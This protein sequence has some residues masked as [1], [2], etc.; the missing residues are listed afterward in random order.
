GTVLAAR[1]RQMI[2]EATA[3]V[4]SVREI[5]QEPSGVLRVLL[6]VGV[7][8]HLMIPVFMA[9]RSTYPLLSVHARMSEDPVGGLLDDIDVAVHFGSDAPPGP[10][11][12]H[13]FV[14][15]TERLIAHAD[16]LRAHGTPASLE[17]LGSHE[18][19]SWHA[20]GEDPRSLPLRI[21]GSFAVE[22]K[23]VTRD[24]H[25]IRQCVVAG[26]GIGLVPDPPLPDPGTSPGD[27]IPVLEEYVG[28]QRAVRVVVPSMLSD[29]PKIKAVLKHVRAFTEM[30]NGT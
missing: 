24:V 1:G 23:L 15:T 17:D 5:G 29:V 27:I 28:R 3:L 7:P 30:L 6:P 16:Y 25:V 26:L 2:Q 4:A 20:P 21:G 22:P 11:V 14:R 13:T 19:F 10:W 9:L 18:L 8:P 12:S